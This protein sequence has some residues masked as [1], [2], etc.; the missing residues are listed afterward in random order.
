MKDL[1]AALD[2]AQL[3]G[4]MVVAK[5]APLLIALLMIWVGIVLV[6]RRLRAIKRRITNTPVAALKGAAKLGADAS[7]VAKDAATLAA[8]QAGKV[9]REHAIPNAQRFV[10]AAAEGA[11]VGVDYA[12]EALGHAAPRAQDALLSVSQYA[13]T[14]ADAVADGAARAA[15]AVLQTAHATFDVAKTTAI[16]TGITAQVKA[17]T[18]LARAKAA[19]QQIRDREDAADKT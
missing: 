10:N 18:F 6:R 16:A 11:R 5:L 1:E 9:I 7:S 3:F 13:K 8:H 17:Q 4:W 14:G 2:G 12:A 19:R 15:P